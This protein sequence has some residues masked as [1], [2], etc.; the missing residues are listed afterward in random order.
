[1]IGFVKWYKADRNYGFVET[2]EGEAF[3]VHAQDIIPDE[4]QQLK[5]LIKDEP[6]EFDVKQTIKGPKAVNV[7]TTWR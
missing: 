2:K 6:V 3:F 5:I 1:M 7:R 4:G